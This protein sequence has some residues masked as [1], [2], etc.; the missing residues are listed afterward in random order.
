MTTPPEMSNFFTVVFSSAVVSALV[1]VCW[2]AYAKHLDRKKEREKEKQ[3]V[4]HIYL[5]L[6]LQL[7]SFAQRC[8]ER[9]YDISVRMDLYG[10]NQ[11]RSAFRG[12][13]ELA[14][15]FDPEPNW[16][17]LPVTLVAE[18]KTL[19]NSFARCNTWIVAQSEWAD[20]DECY[21]FEEERLAIY[22]LK[23]CEGAMRLRTKIGA[24][25]GD[26]DDISAHFEEIIN[27]RRDLYNLNPER[28]NLIPE[29]SAR[30]NYERS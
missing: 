10:R 12:F 23:M 24:A 26:L 7:E 11:D 25:G 4:D 6:M 17:E 1:N 28:S 30:F 15:E 5:L 16:S 13:P 14:L 8:F 20:F 22:A 3:K 29:L 18:M 9:I 21:K 19:I 27:K 2:N